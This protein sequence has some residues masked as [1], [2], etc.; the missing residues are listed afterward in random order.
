MVQELIESEGKLHEKFTKIFEETYST[1]Y[2]I[3]PQVYELSNDKFLF[4]FDPQGSSIPGKGD[5][6]SKEYF[7]RMIRW[8]QKVRD[9]YANNRNSS[10]AH[11]Q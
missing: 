7:L 2:M 9:D 8:T 11:W 3:Q 10:V 1:G 4:V 6:Y 5:I